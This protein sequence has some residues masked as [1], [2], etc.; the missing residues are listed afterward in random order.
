MATVVANFPMPVT[1]KCQKKELANNYIKQ[2]QSAEVDAILKQA[3]ES[4]LI[5]PG[6]WIPVNPLDPHIQELGRFAVNEHNRQT[7][8]KLVFVAVVAGLKKPVEL[9]TLYWLIIEAKDRNGNQNI[10]KAL[11]QETDLEMKK[12]LYFEEVAPPVN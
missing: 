1:A 3:G 7:R 8:D 9:A 6:G 2:F 4:K 5:V 11:V 10:Y 12:L